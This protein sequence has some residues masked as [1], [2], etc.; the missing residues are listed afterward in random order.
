MTGLV[1]ERIDLAYRHAFGAGRNLRDLVARLDFPF[2]KHTEI[3]TGSVVRDHKR[4]H[5]RHVHAYPQSIAGDARL[6]HLEQ[7][8]ADAVAVSDTHLR[9][10][11]A[12]DCEILAK[13]PV[14]EI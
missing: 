11:Q 1:K 10:R 2:L 8:A 14:D 7:R 9:V 4:R 3:E 6:G 12:V 5:L 13:L